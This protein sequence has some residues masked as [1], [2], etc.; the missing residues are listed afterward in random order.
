MSYQSPPICESPTCIPYNHTL[1][2]WSGV[3]N[4]KFCKAHGTKINK[5]PT[6]EWFRPPKYQMNDFINQ[7]ILVHLLKIKKEIIEF[8]HLFVSLLDLHKNLSSSEMTSFLTLIF[9]SQNLDYLKKSIKE[10]LHQNLDMQEIVFR[11]MQPHH[12]FSSSF[13]HSSLH[14]LGFSSGGNPAPWEPTMGNPKT[15][16]TNTIP[17][18]VRRPDS[19]NSSYILL[20]DVLGPLTEA[21]QWTRKIGIL[22]VDKIRGLHHAFLTKLGPTQVSHTTEENFAEAMIWK[23]FLTIEQDSI[24]CQ[25]AKACK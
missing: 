17:I 10:N 6:S 4:N 8:T 19:M 18:A 9:T 3:H 20:L 12:T 15:D 25:Q 21:E 24:I 7:K 1:Q 5:K 23:H 2:E 13:S 11:V 16:V 22:S 14:N